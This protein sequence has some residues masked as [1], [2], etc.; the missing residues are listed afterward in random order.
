MSINLEKRKQA[1]GIVLAKRGI[2]TAPTTRVGV[3]LDVSGSARGFYTSGVMQE[4]LDRLLAVAI[5]FDDNGELDAWTFDNNV[6]ALPTI[7]AADE[8]KYV[9]RA[10]MESGNDM[11]NGTSYAPAFRAAMKHYFGG[12][13]VAQAAAATKSFLGGL[14]GKKPVVEAAPVA[15]STDKQEPAMLLFIT[16]GANDDRDEAAR[17]LREA[18]RTSPMYFNMIG[19]GPSSYFDFLK[20]MADELP[21][22]GFVNLSSLNMTDEELY[23]KVVSQE[24]CDWVKKQA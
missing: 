4:T 5:K 8:G 17:V 22:V 20:E 2:T 6:H 11:W 16:D 10:I 9:K 13:A 3:A 12:S 15:S 18:A 14:F 21:N 7:T 24:F 23:E 19:I 1:V